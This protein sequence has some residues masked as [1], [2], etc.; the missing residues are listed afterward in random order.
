MISKPLGC[1]PEANLIECIDTLPLQMLY[2]S[3]MADTELRAGVVLMPIGKRRTKLSMARCILP[4]S[5][6]PCE[7]KL[8]NPFGVLKP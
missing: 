1:S 2:L 5:V 6:L 7:Q 4:P 8:I 3:A